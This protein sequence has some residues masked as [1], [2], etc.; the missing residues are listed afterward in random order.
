MAIN[1][2]EGIFHTV[3]VA[4]K[5]TPPHCSIFIQRSWKYCCKNSFV[6]FNKVLPGRPVL[7]FSINN[8][9]IFQFISPHL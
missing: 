3:M 9:Q 5:Q 8:V 1:K 2:L 4:K 6:F 7:Y